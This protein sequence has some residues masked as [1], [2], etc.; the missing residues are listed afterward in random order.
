M[1]N[2]WIVFYN[3]FEIV[4]SKL[5]LIILS[6]SSGTVLVSE[7]VFLPRV[8]I[9]LKKHYEYLSDILYAVLKEP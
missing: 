8:M 5:N 6:S 4:F 3:L 9:F 1:K 7:T 2:F